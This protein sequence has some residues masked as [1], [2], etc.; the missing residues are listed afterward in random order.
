MKIYHNFASPEAV[1]AVG[2]VLYF[3]S[4]SNPSRQRPKV[5]KS[6]MRH[7]LPAVFLAI[8][9]TFSLTLNTTQAQPVK[10]ISSDNTGV[11]IG[12]ELRD[13]AVKTKTVNAEQYHLISYEN[14]GYT[15]NIGK[16]R[17]PVSRV[18]IGIP[19]SALLSIHASSSQTS[20]IHGYRPI[21]VPRIV[22]K[23]SPY[24]GL[25]A[26]SDV[27]AL[28]EEY[29][30]D[31]GFYRN[32]RLYPQELATISY[33]GNLRHQRIAVVEI[34][35]VQYNPVTGVLKKHSR[36][37]V[38]INFS[39]NISRNN[40]YN[41]NTSES[42]FT[43][44]FQQY[45]EPKFEESYRNILINYNSAK[46]WR[47]SDSQTYAAPKGYTVEEGSEAVKLFV[48]KTGIYRVNYD[49]ILGA[50]LDPALIDPRNIRIT[51]HGKQIPVYIEGETDGS[52]DPEDFIEFYGI[53]PDSI[54]SRWNV[55]WLIHGKQRG[56]RMIQ[57]SGSPKSPT[58]REV[59]FFS[60][61]N[62]FEEDHLHHK[63]QNVQPD[64]DNP[65]AWFESR[66]H[67]FWDGIEN[68]SSKTEM[69]LDFP[70]YDLAQ[71]MIRPDFE[72]E[73]VGCTNFE[74]NIMIS[75]N[76][77]KVGQ[78]AQWERQD[79]YSYEGQ[80]PATSIQEGLNE[81]RLARIGSNPADGDNKESYPYQVY[82]NWFK[83]T[84]LRKL[85]AVNDTLEFNAPEPQDPDEREI[86]RYNVS[87]FLNPDIQV[88]QL[89]G[90]N[91][92]SRI[93]DLQISSYSLSREDRERLLTIHSILGESSI[94][95]SQLPEIGY[96]VTFEDVG[97][98][99]TK[100][101]AVS[102]R[103][104][105]EPDRIQKDYPSDLKS[106]SNRADYLVISHPKFLEV[107]YELSNWRSDPR[108][109]GF[110]T[111]VIDVT[112]IY[113]EF[114]FGMVS[115]HAI[116]DFL[117]YAYHNWLDPAP[118]YVL[119]LADA[120]YDFL[121]V[122]EEF[123]PEAPELAGFIPSFYIWTTFGQTAAD[124]WYSAID[125]DDGFPDIYLGRI[126]VE[127]VS[128][129]QSVLHKI[130]ANESDINGPWRKQI[131]SIAD[132]DTHA[133]GDEIFR[134]GLEEI[135]KYHTPPGYETEKIYLKDILAE[136]EKDPTETRRPNNVVEDMIREAFGKG[137]IIVQYSGHGGR[138]VWAHEIV[139]S[140]TD[141]ESMI[142]TQTFP[143]LLVFSCYNGYFDLPG[144]L[145]MAEGM[146]R[147]DRRGSVAMLSATR[148][149]Y[150]TG[151]VSLNKFLFDAIFK[152]NLLNIG[153]MTAVSKIKVLL[154]EGMSWL[155]QMQEYTLF[156]DPASRLNIPEYE[157][158]P[159]LV[160]TSVKPGKSLDILPGEVSRVIGSGPSVF[161][162]NIEIKAEFADGSET[163]STVNAI[164]NNY[165]SAS[166]SVPAGISSGTG[167][168]KLFGQSG[169]EAA[170]GGSKFSVDKPSIVSLEHEFTDNGINFYAKVDDD[171]GIS[172]I[173][174]IILR[175]ISPQ[176]REWSEWNMIYDAQSKK[177]TLNKPLPLFNN[178]GELV[179]YLIVEDTDS[180]TVELERQTLPLP[181]Q[182][183]LTLNRIANL[184]RPDISYTYSNDLKTWGVDVAVKNTGTL[185]VTVPIKLAIYRG[186]PDVDDDNN[187][188]NGSNKIAETN[189]EPGLWDDDKIIN[190]FV[191]LEL[192]PGEYKL[193]LWLDP[194]NQYSE[195]SEKDNMYPAV[196]NV[197]HVLLSPTRE[198]STR[199]LD[200]VFSF[201]TFIGTYDKREILKVSYLTESLEANNQPDISY[202][203]LPDDQG[204]GYIVESV[205]DSGELTFSRPAAVEIRF[206]FESFAE[207]VKN[208]IGL[209]GVPEEQMEPDQ[210]AFFEQTLKERTSEM[211]IYRWNQDAK[212]WV[213]VP[214]EPE[215]DNSGNILRRIHATLPEII[216]EEGVTPIN[217]WI[218]PVSIQE[219]ANTPI[220]EWTIIFDDQ[221]NFRLTGDK[222]GVLEVN[223]QPLIGTLGQEFY[224][225]KTGF[226]FTIFQ[227][228]RNFVQGDRFSFKTLV[229]GTI[230]G[231]VYKTGTFTLMS[232]KDVE[233]PSISITIG[234]QNFT[235]GDVV[236]MEPTI[237]ALLYDDNGIDVINQNPVISISR[238]RGEFQQALDDQ[239]SVYWTAES[240]EVSVNYWPGKLEPGEY[241]VMLS[242]QDFN[243]NQTEE[244]AKFVVKR[245]F[246]LTKDTLM[247]YPNPFERET[248]ITFH[249]TSLAEEG[250][251]KIYTVSGRLIKT[252][253]AKHL[254][255]FVNIHWDGK[256]ENGNE[257]AN[258]VYYYK[259][260]LKSEGREDIVQVGKMMKLK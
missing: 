90:S 115:P 121:G 163:I 223:G 120:T 211:C 225:S 124:H 216:I 221:D 210:K 32:N 34:Y 16:P 103:N 123:Y 47:E 40:K 194:E 10:L 180:N 127:E 135:W 184:T 173:E 158:Q 162:G 207:I 86:A 49:M 215:L 57:K 257:V 259:L 71:S 81:L 96:Q 6:N 164:N 222:T 168:L 74:H 186:N 233:L 178:G 27:D 246:E 171:A 141:I 147:A 61:V 93:K 154:K 170:I 218:G 245:E 66:D 157:I 201:N 197:T 199:S 165:D 217:K 70:V 232:N 251:I 117:T 200:S 172:G 181:S 75:I 102:S 17:L 42:E 112:D 94:I 26:S 140:I 1:P 137:P 7:L 258:G 64:P 3:I 148:L 250:I 159:E 101:L 69:T 38:R 256:D 139:F 109:G 185:P 153:E 240:N 77:H 133:A 107:A 224:H 134:I 244:T 122:N 91:A 19:P 22:D 249:L 253:E 60:S 11:S 252:L 55:Y 9:I 130:I 179:Y 237:Q 43:H 12:F 241:E 8:F 33:T 235:D 219:D 129:A 213:Y 203:P 220:D 126:P 73:L 41:R 15:S 5:K 142:E 83:I 25:S 143:F 214:S 128:Q 50:N 174:S 114:G 149:T 160:S 13:F 37:Q 62:Y 82:L 144:E 227:D 4:E 161:T 208:E 236:S 79:I 14:C 104:I 136:V 192:S 97:G 95:N 80:I 188:D 30:E 20:S 255:N 169:V 119:I 195:G 63:L 21:P 206:D 166:V 58:S 146:V 24:S 85:L 182:P 243:G 45:T 44:S 87:S 132:D 248:D 100:Y 230:Q 35:P 31:T 54:Y 176:K 242:V 78:E 177:Y 106:A 150:G 72:I 2:K 53:K 187:V 175:W 205:T 198:S 51:L 167:Y 52:F 193:F 110:R 39:D 65:D 260:R 204:H 152:D 189:F 234:D 155:S 254:V 228:E 190:V 125:G 68:G 138:H 92:V 18:F 84:Y 36:I 111:S 28:T 59:T 247:N 145:S 151:N 46:N 108:G 229:T 113:D 156:G 89:S 29:S 231:N 183:N 212:K 105:L 88:Y 67:W 98:R 202:I 116:K 56:L 239:Y 191:P 209:A 99:N 76:G 131:V 226:R 48:S 23:I 238:D 196:L 118:S